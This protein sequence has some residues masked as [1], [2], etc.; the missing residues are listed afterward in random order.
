MMV[1]VENGLKV[2]KYFVLT[3]MCRNQKVHVK[4]RFSEIR[5][6]TVIISDSSRWMRLNDPLM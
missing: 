2:R 1:L 6:K 5:C 4:V 3:V